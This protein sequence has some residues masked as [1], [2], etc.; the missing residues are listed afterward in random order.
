[1]KGIKA[2]LAGWLLL[3]ATAAQAL[4]EQTVISKFSRAADGSTNWHASVPDDIIP[5]ATGYLVIGSNEVTSNATGYLTAGSTLYALKL[6]TDLS[7][8][9]SF[10]VNG[11]KAMGLPA[12]YHYRMPDVQLLPTGKF[13]VAAEAIMTASPAGESGERFIL[14]RF[15]ADTTLDDTFGSSGTVII[16]MPCS[17]TRADVPS[18]AV[19]STGKIVL[20]G[21]T[22]CPGTG[23][24]GFMTRFSANGVRETAFGESG[25]LRINPRTTGT[26]LTL[27]AIDGDDRL[28]VAGESERPSAAGTVDTFVARL[29]LGETPQLDTSFNVTGH[30]ILAVGGTVDAWPTSLVMQ[31]TNIL[32]ASSIDS[33]SGESA[34]TRLLQTGALDTTMGSAGT[35]LVSAGSF[36]D[37]YVRDIVPAASG[38]Y[39]IGSLN[40]RRA[41]MK[42]TAAGAPDTAD[43][44]F[45]GLGYWR[46][47]LS[48][49][50]AYLR[51]VLQGDKL[52]VAGLSVTRTGT[53]TDNAN[54]LEET[55]FVVSSFS[56]ASGGSTPVVTESSSSSGGGSTDWLALLMLGLMVASRRLLASR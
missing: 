45:D 8:D 56:L 25:F 17:G 36:T 18:L 19:Q 49:D 43:A 10:G 54:S 6:A 28:L 55:S 46:T 47:A 48:G 37:S 33:V 22:L 16:G 23:R 14:A 1:M 15:N 26:W 44:R 2:G 30:R 38:Y 34:L 24:T 27:A 5:T 35:A 29:T 3:V 50:S 11:V 41:I 53:A 52:L 32:V 7:R 31:G 39:L 40:G 20:T 4:T 42:V 21:T 9:T 12:G 13:L 51:G